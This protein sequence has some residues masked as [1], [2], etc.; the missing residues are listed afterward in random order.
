VAYVSP[1]ALWCEKD[2]TSW[3]ALSIAHRTA[4]AHCPES[5]LARMFFAGSF[6][7][8]QKGCHGRATPWVESDADE[9]PCGKCGSPVAAYDY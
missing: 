5:E 3:K 7:C 6:P 8:R 2:W 9:G 4:G 1:C